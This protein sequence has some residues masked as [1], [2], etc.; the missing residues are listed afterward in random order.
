MENLLFPLSS[1]P[2]LLIISAVK[3]INKSEI[4]KI[5]LS[6]LIQFNFQLL[7]L[8]M[9]LSKIN[10]PSPTSALYTRYPH[11]RYLE[12]VIKLPFNLIIDR[13]SKI[14]PMM[15]PHSLLNAEL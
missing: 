5:L 8:V 15:P 12:N 10:E 4:K 2:R 9:T 7:F 13:S 11:W 3:K 1:Q 6:F 14:S